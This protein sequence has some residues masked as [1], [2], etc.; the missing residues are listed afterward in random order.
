VEA[1]QDAA[2]DIAEVLGV[3]RLG[4]GRDRLGER[5]AG[6]VSGHHRGKLADAPGAERGGDRGLDAAR[7]GARSRRSAGNEV[8]ARAAN[9]V[10]IASSGV[11]SG[12]AFST[13]API[14]GASP[15]IPLKTISRLSR[16]YR[17]N[18]LR[19]RPAPAAICST[20]VAS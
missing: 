20:V 4:P 11:C 19:A 17:K 6:E 8:A 13:L 1:A 15:S 9:D 5:E 7:S 10:S 3:P 16:K 2:R 14:A 12:G 18:V